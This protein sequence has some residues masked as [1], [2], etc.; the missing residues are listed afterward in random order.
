MQNR[1]ICCFLVAP[2]R[3]A[4]GMQNKSLSMTQVL[5]CGAAIVTMSMSMGTIRNW[6]DPSASS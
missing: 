4:F 5:V 1:Y 3:A 2:D 6:P